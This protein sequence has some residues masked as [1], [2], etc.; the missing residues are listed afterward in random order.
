MQENTIV[1]ASYV[2][3]LTVG[4]HKEALEN[5]IRDVLGVDIETIL[6]INSDYIKN[7]INTGS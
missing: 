4:Q 1:N 3:R 7:L 6:N 5:Y 2:V